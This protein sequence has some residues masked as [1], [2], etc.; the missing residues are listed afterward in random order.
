VSLLSSI[1]FSRTRTI[2]AAGLASAVIVAPA[3]AQDTRGDWSGFIT[4][5]GGVTPEFEGSGKYQG[6]PYISA[7]IRYKKVALEIRGLGARL[8]VLSSFGEGMFYGGPAINFRLPRDTDQGKIGDPVRFLNKID[9]DTQGGGF[10]GVKLG[11]DENGQGQFR[12]ETTALAGKNGFEAKVNGNYALL[13][14]EKIFLDVS[15]G[16]T[17]GNKENNRTYFGVTTAEAARSGLTVYTPGSGI[18]S[19][20]NGITIGYQFNKRWSVVA[21]GNYSYLVGDVG[22]SPIV[23]GRLSGTDAYKAAGSRSQITAGIGIGWSF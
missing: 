20:D 12:L 23:K 14:N 15:T 9:F 5:G 1:T 2:I 6:I 16:L 8:D 17:Y 18:K 7:D 3:L 21:N 11:G 22:K 10:I 19:I 4:A 13:R